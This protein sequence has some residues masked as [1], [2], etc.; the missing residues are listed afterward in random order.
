MGPARLTQTT[1]L[2]SAEPD[3][4]LNWTRDKAG[5]DAGSVAVQ[6]TALASL[7]RRKLPGVRPI[8]SR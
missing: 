1:R 4:S 3:N 2:V 5:T 8:C 6:A 7:M